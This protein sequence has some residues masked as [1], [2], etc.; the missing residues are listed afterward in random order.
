MSLTEKE[1][2]K[3]K[4]VQN[5]SSL[6][7]KEYIPWPNVTLQ[8]PFRSKTCYGISISKKYLHSHVHCTFIHNSQDMKSI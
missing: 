8:R 2:E 7:S 4:K 6:A 1:K 3:A 5:R